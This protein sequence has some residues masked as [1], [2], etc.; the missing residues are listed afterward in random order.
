MKLKENIIIRR[1]PDYNPE[2]IKKIIRSWCRRLIRGR[3]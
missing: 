1:A 2:N 3:L